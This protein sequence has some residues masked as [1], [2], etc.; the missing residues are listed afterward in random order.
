MRNQDSHAVEEFRLAVD[1]IQE[2]VRSA[3]YTDW[4]STDSAAAREG[5]TTDE[6]IR[7]L[8]ALER[9]EREISKR[10]RE[11]HARIDSL[12]AAP[13][14]L[15]LTF[16]AQLNAYKRAETQVSRERR[17]LHRKID[18][19]AADLARGNVGA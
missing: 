2:R 5:A 14:P 19:L 10:R 8:D 4:T 6:A 12:E 18:E 1:A 15:N 11:L 13:K 16:E 9:H 3:S 7:E 17:L